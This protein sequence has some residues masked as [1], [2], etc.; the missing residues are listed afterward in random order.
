MTISALW[1]RFFW[2]FM[3]MVFAGLVWLQVVGD[4]VRYMPFGLLAGLIVGGAYFAIGVRAML[5]ARR[6]ADLAVA[7]AEATAAAARSLDIDPHA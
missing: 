3:L 1:D 5:A 4:S 7:E 6:R 2:S